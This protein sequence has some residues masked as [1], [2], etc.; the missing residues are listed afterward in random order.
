MRKRIVLVSMLA[1]I[2]VLGLGI[3]SCNKTGVQ[4]PGSPDFNAGPIPTGDFVDRFALGLTDDADYGLIVLNEGGEGLVA[5][6]VMD[7]QGSIVDIHGSILIASDGSVLVVRFDNAGWP[8]H[9]VYNGYVFFFT[10]WTIA[11]VDVAVVAPDGSYE[12]YSQTPRIAQGVVPLGK[13]FHPDRIHELISAQ[14]ADTLEKLPIPSDL[15][16]ELSLFG[17]SMQAYGPSIPPYSIPSISLV[18][19]RNY[20]GDGSANSWAQWVV[21][22]TSIVARGFPDV[23]FVQLPATITD[24]EIVMDG[25]EGVMNPYLMPSHVKVAGNAC[26]LPGLSDIEKM[27]C[28]VYNGGIDGFVMG[29]GVYHQALASHEDELE[30]FLPNLDM[31]EY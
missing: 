28:T 17:R 9:A 11:G 14:D 23:D 10:N 22:G 16:Y 3:Y 27:Y 2:M 15:P 5:T 30:M 29:K 31:F 4:W 26:Q 6:T 12:I 13:P 25:E 24:S 18:P 8:K 19:S 20:G 1:M 21:V 7:G